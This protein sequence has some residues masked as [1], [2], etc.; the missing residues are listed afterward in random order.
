MATNPVRA[1]GSLRALCEVPGRTKKAEPPALI[2]LR[3]WPRPSPPRTRVLSLPL[4]RG[5]CGCQFGNPCLHSVAV[6]PRA[7]PSG[8][9]CTTKVTEP[10]TR[11]RSAPQ[12]Q[13][14]NTSQ[15]RRP[16]NVH[17]DACRAARPTPSARSFA[18]MSKDQCRTGTHLFCSHVVVQTHERTFSTR[19]FLPSVQRAK[20]ARTR[21][22]GEVR[23]DNYI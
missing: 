11:T 21:W 14:C 16:C 5:L 13:T 22:T 4:R 19:R 7:T 23:D 8:V 6:M 1:S 12:E 20:Q 9:W 10:I 18:A 3:R 15:P 2:R 17:D